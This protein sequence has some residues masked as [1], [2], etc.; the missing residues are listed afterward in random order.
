VGENKEIIT[1][2]WFLYNSVIMERGRKQRNYHS[3]LVSVQLSHHGTW[4]K[5][6]KLSLSAGFCTT[7][8]S[9]NVGENKEIITP[10]GFRTFSSPFSS[11]TAGSLQC[12]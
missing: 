7:P 12:A 4:E 11:E 5:T 9:W 10:A 1:L 2:C 3:L 8:S 6:K